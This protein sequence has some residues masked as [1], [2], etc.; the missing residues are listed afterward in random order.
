METPQDKKPQQRPR[1][2]SSNAVDFGFD[3]S[4]SYNS[5]SAPGPNLFEASDSINHAITAAVGT[6]GTSDALA[7][8]PIDPFQSASDAQVYQPFTI[9][10]DADVTGD[11]SYR[12]LLN[13]PNHFF[14]EVN[15]EQFLDMLMNATETTSDPTQGQEILMSHIN[16]PP[17][18][19]NQATAEQNPLTNMPS[20]SPNPL[21]AMTNSPSNAVTDPSPLE[22][23]TPESVARQKLLSLINSPLEIPKTARFAN[24]HPCETTLLP[25]SVAARKA[26]YSSRMRTMGMPTVNSSS[27]VATPTPGEKSLGSPFGMNAFAPARGNNGSPYVIDPPD[28]LPP[29]PRPQFQPIPMNDVSPSPGPRLCQSVLSGVSAPARG[30]IGGMAPTFKSPPNPARF[31][32]KV[33]NNDLLPPPP[34]RPATKRIRTDSFGAPAFIAEI[35]Q[36][37]HNRDQ[38]FFQQPPGDRPPLASHFSDNN[39]NSFRWL[40]RDIDDPEPPPSLVSRQTGYEFPVP[41]PSGTLASTEAE[42]VDDD[43]DVGQKRKMKQVS[44]GSMGESGS[45]YQ[46]AAEGQSEGQGQ[47][48]PNHGHAQTGFQRQSSL[49]GQAQMQNQ[50]QGQTRSPS[51]SQSRPPPPPRGQSQGGLQAQVHLTNKSFSPHTPGAQQRQQTPRLPIATPRVRSTPC[52]SNSGPPTTPTPT[53]RRRTSSIMAQGPPMGTIM[54]TAAVEAA[55]IE[56]HPDLDPRLSQ[57]YTQSPSEPQLQ[58]H[59][60]SRIQT[61][62]QTPSYLPPVRTNP[63]S[64]PNPNSPSMLGSCPASDSNANFST[65]SNSNFIFGPMPD[66]A[67]PTALLNALGAPVVDFDPNFP[68]TEGAEDSFFDDLFDPSALTGVSEMGM[69]RQI[70]MRMHGTGSGGG[71]FLG[72]ATG[73]G[74]GVGV[75]GSDSSANG[76]STIDPHSNAHVNMHA[77]M[78]EARACSGTAFGEVNAATTFTIADPSPHPTVDTDTDANATT[79]TTTDPTSPDLDILQLGLSMGFGTGIYNAEFE[80]LGLDE[81]KEFDLRE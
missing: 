10:N 80:G 20:S 65:D 17:N 40:F 54:E 57:P 21:A 30:W 4:A 41:L 46:M 15:G 35:A 18:P 3:P 27:L 71:H 52:L 81:T 33:L 7:G 14:H 24:F 76:N 55:M 22:P 16:M 66:V 74:T 51:Q 23:E 26:S 78:G 61:P 11:D 37:Q 1:T 62:I 5:S 44:H 31:A 42:D 2:D 6:M 58:A 75:Q 9:V 8:G 70:R 63:A 56:D 68:A 13:D 25:D 29:P 67:M 19:D 53:S 36:D 34:N 59:A 77:K 64:N 49:L 43:C 39:V 69:R 38:I 32:Q 45:Q 60:P 12:G 50:P 73:F 48:D 47:G 79:N 72:P 28:N